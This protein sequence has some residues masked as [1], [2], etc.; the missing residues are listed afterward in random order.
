MILRVSPQPGVSRPPRRAK[1]AG[2]DS[3][4][5]A[6]LGLAGPLPGDSVLADHLEKRRPLPDHQD[7][8][9]A[10]ETSRAKLPVDDPGVLHH[11]SS[12]D[13]SAHRVDQT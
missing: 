3:G 6:R 4:W 8:E 9:E 10:S 7:P 13:D 1:L 5:R 12:S 11:V 2:I